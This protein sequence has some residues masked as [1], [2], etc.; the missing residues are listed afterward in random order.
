MTT[1]LTSYASENFGYVQTDHRKEPRNSR[2]EMNIHQ[3]RLDLSSLKKLY[4]IENQMEKSPFSEL[5]V[6]LRNK[7]NFLRRVEG[8]KKLWKRMLEKEK[9]LF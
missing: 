7:F 9:P 2:L 3:L 1:I 6:T 5:R 4:K 8:Q